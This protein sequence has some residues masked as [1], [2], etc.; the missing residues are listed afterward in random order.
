MFWLV[1]GQRLAAA[2]RHMHFFDVAHRFAG[3]FVQWLGSCGEFGAGYNIRLDYCR[4]RSIRRTFTNKPVNC[5]SLSAQP[6][7]R[8]RRC[9]NPTLTKQSAAQRVVLF[10]VQFDD[11]LL[12]H[13]LLL[14]SA[15]HS[16]KSVSYMYLNAADRQLQ[17]LC[18]D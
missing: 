9:L 13:V 12:T 4:V 16:P 1:R 7:T 18:T 2:T 15:V 10:A 17:A 3:L 5:S 6:S 8:R 14:P 11:V